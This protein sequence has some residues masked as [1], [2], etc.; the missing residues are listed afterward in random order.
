MSVDNKFLVRD[1]ITLK[2]TGLGSSGEGV[3]KTDGFTVFAHGA[4]A[5]ETVE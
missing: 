4:L 5:D 1:K 2:V 3:G